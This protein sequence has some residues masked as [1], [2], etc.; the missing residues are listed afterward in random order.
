MLKLKIIF[1]MITVFS[2]CHSAS[3]SNGLDKMNRNVSDFQKENVKLDE[4]FFHKTFRMEI[5]DFLTQIEMLAKPL[6]RNLQFSVETVSAF[7]GAV[8]YRSCS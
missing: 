2:T 4:S 8:L 3:I 6:S 5:L 7:A 1:V